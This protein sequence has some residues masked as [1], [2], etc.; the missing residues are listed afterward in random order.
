MSA[1]VT[2]ETSKAD[3][4]NVTDQS[5]QS[6]STQGL[7]R[8]QEN[9]GQQNDPTENNSVIPPLPIIVLLLCLLVVAFLRNCDSVLVNPIIYDTTTDYSITAAKDYTENNPP[10]VDT[11]QA[12]DS[13]SSATDGMKSS[14]DQSLVLDYDAYLLNTVS[15]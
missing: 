12:T 7:N 2:R 9:P 11:P 6:P 8:V 4:T 1:D 10:P 5:R 3:A 13:D 14:N 15:K